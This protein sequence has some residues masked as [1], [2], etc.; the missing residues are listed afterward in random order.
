MQ[1]KIVCKTVYQFTRVCVSVWV[2][3]ALKEWW[4][5][6]T[7]FILF[8]VGKHMYK[9]PIKGARPLN[10]RIGIHIID[11]DNYFP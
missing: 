11:F 10:W 9:L 7:E 6:H 4:S 2:V 1:T 3:V 8:G 5:M